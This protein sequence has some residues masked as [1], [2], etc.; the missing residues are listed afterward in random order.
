MILILK[1]CYRITA[2][3]ILNFGYIFKQNKYVDLF[4]PIPRT[5]VNFNNG[6]VSSLST[7]ISDV[8]AVWLKKMAIFPQV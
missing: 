8:M 4:N 1:V 2:L 3:I 7:F 5:K 6:I